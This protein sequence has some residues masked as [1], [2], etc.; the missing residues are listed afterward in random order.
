VAVVIAW[1]CPV[2]SCRMRTLLPRKQP[3]GAVSR[4]RVDISVRCAACGAPK[5]VEIPETQPTDGMTTKAE[6]GD[7]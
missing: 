4:K 5:Q 1:A 6:L 7:R 2:C 3:A